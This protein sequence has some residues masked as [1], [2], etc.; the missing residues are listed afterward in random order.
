MRQTL[1]ALFIAGLLMTGAAIAQQRPQDQELQTAIRMETVTGDLSKA[2]AQYQAI[3]SKYGK[4]D[5]TV[6][7]TALLRMAEC[8][9]KLGNAHAK[10]LYERLVRDFSDRPESIRARAMLTV[11]PAKGRP[12]SVGSRVVWALKG[13]AAIHGKASP[14]GRYIPYLTEHLFL[15]DLVTGTD[16]QLT[17]VTGRSLQEAEYAEGSAFS[18]DGRQLAYGWR[19]R[20]RNVYQLRVVSLEGQGIPRSSVVLDNDNVEWLAPY[21]W[22]PD[23]RFVAVLLRLQDGT[24]QIAMVSVAT[25]ELRP[26]KSMEWRAS[27]NLALSPD[28]R[29][30]AFDLADDNRRRDLHVLASDGS[31]ETSLVTSS[32]DEGLVGWSPDGTHVVYVGDRTGSMDLW[33]IGVAAGKAAGEPQLLKRDVGQ[34]WPMG[35]ASSGT[36]LGVTFSPPLSGK[37][38]LTSLTSSGSRSAG[39]TDVL[40]EF[41]GPATDVQWSRD[42]RSLAAVAQWF[43]IRP[44]TPRYADLMTMGFKVWHPGQ[45]EPREIHTNLDYVNNFVWS[46]D[47]HSFIVAGGDRKRRRGLFKVNAQTGE[48]LSILRLPDSDE[49]PILIPQDEKPDGRIYIKV[50]RISGRRSEAAKLMAVDLSSG[51]GRDVIP[52]GARAQFN[53]LRISG[54]T[55]V[56]LDADPDARA[57]RIVVSRIDGSQPRELFRATAPETFARFASANQQVLWAPDSR[58]LFVVKATG[59]NADSSPCASAGELWQVPLDAAP[60]RINERPALLVDARAF[61]W[62]QDGR[63]LLL[64]RGGGSVGRTELW[65]W[66]LGAEPPRLD[67]TLDGGVVAPR[68]SPEG[69]WLAYTVRDQTA[70][71]PLEIVSFENFLSAPAPGRV[72]RR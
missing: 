1:S 15:H 53:I 4:T 49:Q 46:A 21:D 62:S 30:L 65:R 60:V 19:L 11:D 42:G 9:Q 41:T 26:L 45:R 12:A 68:M 48:T 55:M 54:D 32:T 20:G 56:R 7:A 37:L 3:V 61:A 66:P 64:V 22:T 72:G 17:N 52:Y 47:G 8:H 35:V 6:A 36:V 59:C 2:I 50:N 58:A 33:S 25:G 13:E 51:A 23:G 27:S 34:F 24:A 63:S 39:A 43:G 5:R 44:L 40:D 69:Q 18:R 29:Y 38:K 71:R 14:D 70:S 10:A 31:A 67:T 16:R 28:G 57:E